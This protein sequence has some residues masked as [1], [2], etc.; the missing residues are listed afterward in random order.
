VSISSSNAR[1]SDDSCCC[2]KDAFHG[3]IPSCCAFPRMPDFLALEVVCAY[4]PAHSRGFEG[5][6]GALTKLM[7]QGHTIFDP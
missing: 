4:R 3:L 5:K 1:K 2:K 6:K 7:H